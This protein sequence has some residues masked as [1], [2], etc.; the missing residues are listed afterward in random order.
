M[1]LEFIFFENGNVMCFDGSGEQVSKHQKPWIQLFLESLEAKGVDPTE[2]S[3]KLPIGKAV[4]FKTE[5]GDWNW[6]IK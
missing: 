1:K 4:P 6:R 3:F 2:C 5:E